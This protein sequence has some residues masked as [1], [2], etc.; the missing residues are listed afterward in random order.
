VVVQ[1]GVCRWDDVHTRMHVPLARSVFGSAI[2][3]DLA[4]RTPSYTLHVAARG[5]FAQDLDNEAEKVECGAYCVAVATAVVCMAVQHQKPGEFV[6]V[7]GRHVDVWGL[8]RV[9]SVSSVRVTLHWLYGEHCRRSSGA[10]HEI[11]RR[12]IRAHFAPVT[13]TQTSLRA[14]QLG[15]ARAG[16]GVLSSTT[17]QG[18][19]H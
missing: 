4:T 8:N 2:S 9:S 13:T 18:R 19:Q 5:V 15:M 17:A 11:A 7:R 1:A 14:L 6:E 16:V 12:R 3:N 10:S